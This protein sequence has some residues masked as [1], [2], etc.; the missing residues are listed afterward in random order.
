MLAALSSALSAC[1]ASRGPLTATPSPRTATEISR[2]SE[3]PSPTETNA[4]GRYRWQTY[5]DGHTG[6]RFA[7]PTGW[8]VRAAQCG[9]AS[10][11]GVWIANPS[12]RLA[13][14]PSGGCRA[15]GGTWPPGMPRLPADGVVVLVQISFGG[16]MPPPLYPQNTRLPLHLSDFQ[17]VEH[18][19]VAQL[20][21][22]HVNRYSVRVWEGDT[23][24]KE[25]ERAL[26]RMVRSIGPFATPRPD[27]RFGD[28]VDGWTR[29]PLLAR[30]GT[31]EVHL[32]AVAGLSPTDAWAVGSYEHFRWVSAGRP[33]RLLDD[34]LLLHWD[35]TRWEQQL[36]PGTR[37]INDIEPISADD[38]WAAGGGGSGIRRWDGTRW[39]FVPRPLG[40]LG[41]DGV[42]SI[43]ATGPDAAWAVGVRHGV[44]IEHWDGRSWSLLD[45]LA[46]GREFDYDAAVDA[47]SPTDAWIAG[48]SH[49]QA[50]T[51]HWDGEA[52]RS[53]P[54]PALRFPRLLAVVDFGPDDAWVAGTDYADSSGRAPAHA[55]VEHWNGSTWRRVRLPDLPRDSS[56]EHLSGSGPDD[57]WA[58]G[59]GYDDTQPQQEIVL[60][61]DGDAWTRIDPPGPYAALEDVAAAPGDGDW[62]VGLDGTGTLYRP[63]RALLARS[64]GDTG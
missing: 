2:L 57:L 25:D 53:V 42:Q 12:G 35:G 40:G 13:P 23:V 9:W 4:P 21:M 22:H 34:P 20:T 45:P 26:R 19:L 27:P 52:W 14:P 31:V 61:Y 55:V 5:R 63:D 37:G 62:L 47:S 39:R 58:L 28:C 56:L 50:F 33:G 6:F 36:V 59:W 54:T 18:R 11:T 1:T 7:Y 44:V 16:G 30:P 60:H 64:C 32:G 49:E 51:L 29:V 3:S 48:Y 10:A 46:K 15:G 8:S 43:A 38:V 17:R 24:A 41:G